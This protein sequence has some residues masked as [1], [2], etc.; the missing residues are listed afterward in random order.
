MHLKIWH[1]KN[2]FSFDKQTDHGRI[3]I[4]ELR[5]HE[6][7]GQNTNKTITMIQPSLFPLHSIYIHRNTSNVGMVGHCPILCS[8]KPH[9][10]EV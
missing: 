6:Y 4:G 5:N 10:Q 8:Y 1:K 3:R 7:K 2:N 9:F